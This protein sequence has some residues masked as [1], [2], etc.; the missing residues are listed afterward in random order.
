MSSIHKAR[1]MSNNELYYQ[2]RQIFK[3]HNS[4]SKKMMSESISSFSNYNLPTQGQTNQDSQSFYGS[5]NQ[6]QYYRQ[7]SQQQ[8]QTYYWTPQREDEQNLE[9]YEKYLLSQ[10]NMKSFNQHF[11]TSAQDLDQKQ[12]SNWQN[13]NNVVQKQESGKCRANQRFSST[14]LSNNKISRLQSFSTPKNQRILGNS[15]LKGQQNNYSQ[16]ININSNND[17]QRDNNEIFNNII[18]QNYSYNPKIN[19]NQQ[20]QKSV[21]INRLRLSQQ[22]FQPLHDPSSPLKESLQKH[23]REI[24]FEKF[25][26]RKSLIDEKKSDDERRFNNYKEI[27]INYNNT[28]NI[29]KISGRNNKMYTQRFTD[30]NYDKA[31][32]Q[33]QKFY[34]ADNFK[35]NF[36]LEK[37]KTLQKEGRDVYP[38]NIKFLMSRKEPEPDLVQKQFLNVKP[39]IKQVNMDIQ[40]G[41]ELPAQLGNRYYRKLEKHEI[42]V[43]L[44]GNDKK[45]LFKLANQFRK[46]ENLQKQKVKYQRSKS[47]RMQ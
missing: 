39:S 31:N 7:L 15:N 38:A 37:Q 8:N 23:K 10:P 12:F 17:D 2:I 21:K 45:N 44:S 19:R 46:Q 16:I 25:S 9:Q 36:Q 32:A 27:K 42:K 41:R 28:P 14:I 20:N 6:P 43:D 11:R 22:L 40:S 34:Y 30:V 33:F 18:V 4:Q 47:L 13:C 1:S 5:E 24:K 29:S 35:C 3:K 26:P